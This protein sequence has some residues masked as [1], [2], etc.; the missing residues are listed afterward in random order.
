MEKAEKPVRP[1]D[2]AKMRLNRKQKIF[3]GTGLL[4]AS[5]LAWVIGVQQA[6]TMIMG[7]MWHGQTNQVETQNR[8]SDGVQL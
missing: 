8:V 4:T 6:N 3:I 1:E 2:V 7:G 5:A